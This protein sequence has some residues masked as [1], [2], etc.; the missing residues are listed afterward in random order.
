MHRSTVWPINRRHLITSTS[1]ANKLSGVLEIKQVTLEHRENI[2]KCLCS[3]LQLLPKHCCSFQLFCLV[4][5]TLHCYT[6]LY[7]YCNKITQSDLQRM[8]LILMLISMQVNELKYYINNC[9]NLD[10]VVGVDYGGK[11]SG[12]KASPS[13]I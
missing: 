7:T 1:S 9:E 11:G 3:R 5:V 4:T 2:E 10:W 12:N 8:V 6:A 13:R